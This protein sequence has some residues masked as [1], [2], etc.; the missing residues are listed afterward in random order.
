MSSSTIS[1]VVVDDHPLFRRGVV[2]L[3][4][5]SDEMTVIAEYDSA[6]SLLNNID[7]TYP[8]ILLLD[9]QMPDQSGLEVLR[10]LRSHDQNLKIIIITACNDQEMLLEALRF[11]ANGFL[12]KDTPPDEI[13][14]QLLSAVKGNVVINAGAVTSLASHLREHQ[15]EPTNHSSS[16]AF[17]QMTERERETLF[18]ISKGLNNKLIARELGISD[19]TVKVYV[20]NLLR[21]LNLHS[22]LE[23]AAWAHN[24]QSAELP[25]REG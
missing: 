21:K 9:L 18:Y 12:Q 19:G 10:Q 8:D 24:Q 23:L 3:L 15:M 20:K 4:N 11:G 17:T 1:V 16:S 13:L 5:D 7:D 6:A 2:E 25:S 14:S 22:R